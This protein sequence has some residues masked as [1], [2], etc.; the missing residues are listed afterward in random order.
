MTKKKWHLEALRVCKRKRENDRKK[1]EKKKRIVCCD[2]KYFQCWRKRYTSMPNLPL[3]GFFCS[4]RL[5]VSV[6]RLLVGKTLEQG[7]D[8]L[9]TPPPYLS[10]LCFPPF[11][12]SYYY[13]YYYYYH[14]YSCS[15][16]FF[17]VSSVAHCCWKTLF[18]WFLIEVRLCVCARAC[19]CVISACLCLCVCVCVYACVCDGT[20]LLMTSQF[21]R[22]PNDSH[23]GESKTIRVFVCI[24]HHFSLLPLPYLFL[25]LFRCENKLKLFLFLY[26]IYSF[27]FISIEKGKKKFNNEASVFFSLSFTWLV[28]VACADTVK[29]I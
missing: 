28:F 7:I 14:Y 22:F 23:Y 29:N 20:D 6:E 16:P 26:F 25:P 2:E 5:V 13:Y 4:S 8:S 19:Q 15:L 11:S 12:V 3:R 10:F 9:W 1:R 17:K 24:S 18:R 21:H 27:Y